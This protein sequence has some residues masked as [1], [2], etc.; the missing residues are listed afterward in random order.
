[1]GWPVHIVNASG[2]VINKND[3]I[4]IVY[5]EHRGWEHPGGISFHKNAALSIQ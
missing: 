5:L 1:M 4:L 2:I 3:E